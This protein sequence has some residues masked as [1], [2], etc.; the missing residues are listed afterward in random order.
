MK[1][2]FQN[3]FLSIKSPK[4]LFMMLS[5]KPDFKGAIG[6]IILMGILHGL[7]AILFDQKFAETFH[8]SDRPIIWII[9]YPFVMGLL[10]FIGIG[11][12][13]V[14]ETLWVQLCFKFLRVKVRF[15]TILSVIIYSL[16]PLFLREIVSM[17]WPDILV[18]VGGIPKFSYYKT[19]LAPFAESYLESYPNLFHLF[20]KVELFT[21]WSIAL[22][23]IGISIIGKISYKKSLLIKVLSLLIS[24][25][26]IILY[27]HVK[28]A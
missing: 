3:L 28:H 25:F 22:S 4:K 9:L 1:T 13:S 18:K 15:L 27:D 6:I 12:G 21:I 20:S 19:S 5:E 23:V 10:L 16:I 24:F 17:A 8:L 14:I 26:A 2:I 7:V 11:L